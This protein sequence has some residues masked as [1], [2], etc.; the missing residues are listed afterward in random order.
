MLPLVVVIVETQIFGRL[1]ENF[2][3]SL[4]F[5]KWLKVDAMDPVGGLWILWRTDVRCREDD[6]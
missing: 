2:L 1:A 4:N 6:C 3:N 5:G